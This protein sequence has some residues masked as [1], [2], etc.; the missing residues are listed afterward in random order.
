MKIAVTHHQMRNDAAE[1]ASAL[2]EAARLACAS[3]ADAIVCPRIPSFAALDPA[4]RETLLARIEGCAEGAALLVSFADDDTGPRVVESLLGRT[5][6]LGG[7]ACLREKVLRTLVAEGVDTVVWRPGA[8]S[9]LQ[10]EAILEYALEC[11]PALAGLLVVAECSG[12]E[13]QDG[14]RGTSAIIHAGELVA[15]ATGLGD[16]LLIAEVEVPIAAPEP[17]LLLPGLPPILAQRLAVHEGR[18]PPVDYLAD[19]F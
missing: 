18:K 7:D 16:E 5:A 6:L 1:D 15:E 11:S 14:C 10:A 9:E 8:E 19:L 12:G 17:S 4:E 2:V 3:G 13:G